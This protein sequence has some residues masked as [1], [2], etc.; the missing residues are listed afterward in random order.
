MYLPEFPTSPAGDLSTLCPFCTCSA[1]VLGVMLSGDGT[2]KFGGVSKYL[3]LS[4]MVK[5][6]PF[7][8]SKGFPAI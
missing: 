7:G 2:N 3:E 6:V 5:V 4:S 8:G 1:A